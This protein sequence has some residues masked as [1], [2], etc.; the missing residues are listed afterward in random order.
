MA[1]CYY[2][3]GNGKKC[4]QVDC[5]PP[6][7]IIIRIL[8]FRAT[9]GGYVKLTHLQTAGVAT[10]KSIDFKSSPAP[11]SRCHMHKDPATRPQRERERERERDIGGST[12]TG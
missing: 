1:R 6:G 2:A 10:V 3:R 8:S 4:S 5:T 7:D 11:V 9:S 12:S